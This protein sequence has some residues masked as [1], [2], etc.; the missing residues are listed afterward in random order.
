VQARADGTLTDKDRET[1]AKAKV[2][3]ADINEAHTLFGEYYRNPELIGVTSGL[4]IQNIKQVADDDTGVVIAKLTKKTLLD[5]NEAGHIKRR[6]GEHYRGPSEFVDFYMSDDSTDSAFRMR[7]RP[8]LYPTI[9]RTIF[10]T[11]P[12]GSW[13]LVKGRKLSDI[14]MF[15]VKKMKRIDV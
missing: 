12:V 11:A 3:Y 10:E 6:G 5:E 8:E 13:Y 14:D 15:I 7:I 2:K 4:P 9:G 1:L